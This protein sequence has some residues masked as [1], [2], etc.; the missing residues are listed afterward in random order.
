MRYRSVTDRYNIL[1]HHQSAFLVTHSSYGG[2]VA[3]K[4]E[5]HYAYTYKTLAHTNISEHEMRIDAVKRN[6]CD[7]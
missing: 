7:H 1:L 3:V 6:F 4:M 5:T 2:S